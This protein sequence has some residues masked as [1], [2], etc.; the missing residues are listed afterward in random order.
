MPEAAG[1]LLVLVYPHLFLADVLDDGVDPDL[2]LFRRSLALVTAAAAGVVGGSGAE[3]VGLAP[4]LV[5]VQQA[6]VQLQEAIVDIRYAERGT[7]DVR[8]CVGCTFTN[9][10]EYVFVSSC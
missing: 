9:I 4:L 7:N 8:M 6:T 10:G 1:I 3:I 2:L 5:H